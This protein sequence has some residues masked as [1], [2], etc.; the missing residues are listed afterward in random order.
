MALSIGVFAWGAHALLKVV[1]PK[2]EAKRVAIREIFYV[3]CAAPMLSAIVST[4]LEI[5][6]TG[7]LML[8]AAAL[9]RGD[10][11]ERAGVAMAL[12]ANWKL[13]PAPTIL[14][15]LLVL[16]RNGG[17]K[18]FSKGLVGGFFAAWFLPRFFGSWDYI[19]QQESVWASSLATFTRTSV[20]NFEN[21][22]TFIKF[23]FGPET[24]WW[25]VQALSAVAG[26]AAAFCVWT[27][28]WILFAAALGAAFTMAFSPLGQNSALILTAPLLIWITWLSVERLHCIRE[29]SLFL[30][31][32]ALALIVPYSD[33]IPLD[34]R[35]WMHALSVKQMLLL[36]AT[37]FALYLE[38]RSRSVSSSRRTL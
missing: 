36:A 29:Q 11:L 9:I 17:F 5:F 20:Y 24:P 35:E 7:V 32:V 10:R 2:D 38:L 4:K 8:A 31:A 3:L 26:L 27:R 23:A 33:L 15:W 25:L 34:F 14:L 12:M 6:M 28:P 21:V 19:S 37:F 13:Q 1:L 22:F 18:D 16:L 30:L